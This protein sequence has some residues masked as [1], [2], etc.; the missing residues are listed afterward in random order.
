MCP[1]CF[2]TCQHCHIRFIFPAP[3]ACTFSFFLPSSPIECRPGWLQ[4]WCY[5]YHTCHLLELCCLSQETA[6]RQRK[7]NKQAA[8]RGE[9]DRHKDAYWKGALQPARLSVSDRFLASRGSSF[10]ICEHLQYPG[11]QEIK[12]VHP[13]GNQPWMF[14]GRKDAPIPWPPDAKSRLIRKDPDPG[15]DWRQEEKGAAEEEMVR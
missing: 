6:Q 2:T 9:S 8:G 14:T 5:F 15:K 1:R 10:H 4:R 12:L 3:N 13:K 7:W 11:P